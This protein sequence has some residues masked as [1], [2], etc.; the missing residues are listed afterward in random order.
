MAKVTTAT[1]N[2]ALKQMDIDATMVKGNGYY[3]FNVREENLYD[4]D[5]VYTNSL[6]GYKLDTIVD[7][8]LHGI[9]CE[10]CN[11]HDGKLRYEYGH[12]HFICEKCINS[13]V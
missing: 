5:S 10:N 12:K 6:S 7:E 2:K 4:I 13:G 11:G 1:V 3:Y 8:V 9:H